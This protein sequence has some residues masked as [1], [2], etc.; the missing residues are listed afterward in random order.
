[1]C[2][3]FSSDMFQSPFLFPLF[4]YIFLIPLLFAICLLC[5][6]PQYL[7]YFYF[8]GYVLFCFY[9]RGEFLHAFRE[10]PW[11]IF[12]SLNTHP[13]TDSNPLGAKLP[14][15]PPLVLLFAIEC[16]L[17]FSCS[18]PC[19][20]INVLL[21]WLEWQSCRRRQPSSTMHKILFSRNSSLLKKEQEAT[22]CFLHGQSSNTI[23]FMAPLLLS[24]PVI[25][26]QIQNWIV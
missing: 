3:L 13:Q 25:H 17:F 7:L 5:V 22:L 15:A 10:K 26:A 8:G 12:P 20:E 18:A 11:N 24:S 16:W 2:Y 9:S 19:T 23:F 14:E 4:F 1:M 21:Q 6:F